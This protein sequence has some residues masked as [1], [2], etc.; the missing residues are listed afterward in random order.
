MTVEPIASTLGESRTESKAGKIVGFCITDTPSISLRRRAEASL[1]AI[2]QS[3]PWLTRLDLDIGQTRVLLWGHGNLG[4]CLHRMPDGAL[5]VVNGVRAESA[6]WRTFTGSLDRASDLAELRLPFDGRV[7][8]LKIDADGRSWTLWN[9]WCGSIPV[10]Y[11]GVDHGHI[12]CTLE[13]VVVR[14]AGFAADDFFLPGLVSLLV[15]GHYLGD[16]TLFRGM[17]VALPDSMSE[18]RAGH[19]RSQRMW[20]VEPSDSRWGRGWDELIEEMNAL[21]RSAVVGEL[22]TES[23]WILPLSGGLDSRLIAAL[24]VETGAEV[25][26]YTYGPAAWAETVYAQQVARVLALPWERVPVPPDYLVRYTRFW[27]EWFGSALHCHGMYQM[28]FLESLRSD[29]RGSILQG[30]MGD[31]LAGNHVVGLA[32]TH[33]VSEKWKPLTREG[34]F[35][36]PS[37]V[38]VLMRSPEVTECLD[39]VAEKMQQELAQVDGAWYQQLMFLDFWNRQ[40]LF[41]YYQPAMYDYYRGV[42]TPFFNVEYSRFCLSLPRLALEGRRLQKE[43]MSRFYPSIATI[44]GTFGSPIQLTKSYL[45][46]RGLAGLLPSLLRRGP[47]QEFAVSGNT[48]QVH[49]LRAYRDKSLWPLDQC[50][51]DMGHMLDLDTLEHV[52]SRAVSGDESAYNLLRPIQTVARHFVSE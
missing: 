40:R 43:M 45:I 15:N 17:K 8:L 20:T 14:A 48:I 1:E 18:W 21:M 16:W 49:A 51:R 37:R 35:W 47:F 42:S 23:A 26:A 4:P 5:L 33:S 29:V 6:S 46:R 34:V 36:P 52:Y 50:Y 27:L 44:A 13:P 22:Q 2:L 12:V 28:P 41:V 24:A 3:F 39:I 9:D 32:A 31:P 38:S 25:H 7:N 19:F 30:F 11:S 10:F